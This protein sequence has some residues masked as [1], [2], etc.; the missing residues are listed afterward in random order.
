MSEFDDRDLSRRLRAAAGSDPDFADAQQAV[1]SRVVRARRRRTAVVSGAA[2]ALLI[3]FGVVAAVNNDRG[4]DQLRTADTGVTTPSVDTGVTTSA[5]AD[6]S[7]TSTAL[8]T[9]SVVGEAITTA[10]TDPAQTVPATD[11]PTAATDSTAQPTV[12]P[13][14]PSATTMPNQPSPTVAPTTPSTQ[15]NTTAPPAAPQVQTFTSKGNSITVQ[16]RDGRMELLG[17]T[18]APGWSVHDQHVQWDEIEVKFQFGT[19]EATIHLV[20]QNGQMQ[21]QDGEPSHLEDE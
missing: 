17:V 6:T 15:P 12:P 20:L 9:T 11:V 10:V 5:H 2:V 7:T 3:S 21:P 4:A 8:S 16:L 18:P 19:S 1:H 14:P 13:P